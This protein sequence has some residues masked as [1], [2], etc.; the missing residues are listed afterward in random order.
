MEDISY[1]E[2]ND[3]PSVGVSDKENDRGKSSFPTIAG[4][5]FILAGVFS[6]LTWASLF[7]FNFASLDLS[8]FQQEGANITAAQIRTIL[9][10]CSTVGIV[11]SIF[12]LLGG[13]FAFS[14][15]RWNIAVVGGIVGMFTIGPVFVSSIL[16][17]VGVVLIALSKDKFQ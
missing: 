14:K 9:N 16:S 5:L 1:G 15:K 3:L 12:P 4:V 2:L 13:V 17:F 7:F 6:L 10:V 11:L 8:I